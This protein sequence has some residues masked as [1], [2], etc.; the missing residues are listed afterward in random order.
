MDLT[1]HTYPIISRIENLP[2]DA[3]SLLSISPSSGDG[4]LILASNSIVFVD[5][6]SH[7]AMIPANG[8]AT[9]VT[10][11]PVATFATSNVLTVSRALT[12]AGG[13]SLMNGELPHVL[14]LEG[15]KVEF[16][17]DNT[18]F[19][20]TSEGIIHPI[21]FQK[22]GGRVASKVTFGAPIARTAA[23]S[24]LVRIGENHL[25]LGST[26]GPSPLIKIVKVEEEV[27]HEEGEVNGSAP[28]DN[29]VVEKEAAMDLDD[30]ESPFNNSRFT[31]L[32]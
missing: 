1:S 9:R 12:D 29:V 6:Q 27:V 3:F 4:L 19:V 10:E 14:E 31:F 2:Y 5:Q 11:M 21:E 23:P 30:G 22:D 24:A 18:A 28:A 13:D 25:F 17:D 26:T 16:V 20:V 15:A 8:W 7:A 32:I